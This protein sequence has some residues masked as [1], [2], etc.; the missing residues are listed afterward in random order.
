MSNQFLQSATM[1]INL[2]GEDAIY[3]RVQAGTYDPSTGSVVNTETPLTIKVYRKQIK[4]TTFNYPN[5]IGKDAII[6]YIS[7]DSLVGYAPIPNDKISFGTTEY[8]VDS[9]QSHLALGTICLYRLV[10]VKG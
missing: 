8:Y 9:L 10:C 2:H 7:A 4:A 1:M 3:T 5:L 6:S